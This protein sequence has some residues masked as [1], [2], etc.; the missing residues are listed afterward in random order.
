MAVA[1]PVAGGRPESR[2]QS[3]D[4]GCRDARKEEDD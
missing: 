4:G 1:S 3:F 2:E